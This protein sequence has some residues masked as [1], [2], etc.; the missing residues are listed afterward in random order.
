VGG[1]D[2]D[3]DPRIARSRAKLLD[4]ATALLVEGGPRAVTVDAVTERSGVAKSTLYRQWS[5]RTELLVDVLRSN[6]PPTPEVDLSL[7]FEAALRA[8]YSDAVRSFADPE[9]ARI[10]P[11]LFMLK[12]QLAEVDE[13]T[14]LDNDHKMSVLGSILALGVTEGRI[15][16]GLD[17]FT[18]AASLFGPIVFSIVVGEGDIAEISAFAIDR[19]LDSFGR[20]EQAVR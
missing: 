17:P 16:D 12:R 2:V 13:L 6:I 5:S 20:T 19:F 15:P 4:A 18:V 9:W 7:G 3:T 10:L 14:E 1:I 8:H 11:A